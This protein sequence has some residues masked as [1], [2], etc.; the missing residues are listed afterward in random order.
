MS[1]EYALFLVCTPPAWGFI[2]EVKEM[3]TVVY[4]LIAV[5][6]AIGIAALYTSVEE[7]P[8]IDSVETEYPEIDEHEDITR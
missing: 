8:E 7:F 2:L 4:L 5:L 3:T 1:F 6:V